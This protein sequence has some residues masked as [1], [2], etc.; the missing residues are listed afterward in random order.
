M[1]AVTSFY[2]FMSARGRARILSNFH[3]SLG[4]LRLHFYSL[5]ISF[6]GFQARTIP[7]QP[8]NCVTFSLKHTVGR[9]VGAQKHIHF[10][11]KYNFMNH[12]YPG[13]IEFILGVYCQNKTSTNRKREIGKRHKEK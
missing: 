2:H 8:I 11:C 9:P 12:I 6:Y 13:N 7:I 4:I 1:S 10:M 3:S 5:H